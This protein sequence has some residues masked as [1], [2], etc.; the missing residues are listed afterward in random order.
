VYNCVWTIYT[1]LTCPFITEYSISSFVW[2]FGRGIFHTTAEG[3]KGHG[4]TQK[5][6]H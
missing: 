5:G 4:R 3:A 2:K 1:I 6:R